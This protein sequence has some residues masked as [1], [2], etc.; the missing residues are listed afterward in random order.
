M[1]SKGGVRGGNKAAREFVSEAEE[2]LETMRARLADLSDCLG[3]GAEADPDLVNALF[4]A[5]HS[6]KALAGLFRFDPISSLAHKLEDVLDGLRLGRVAL[7]PPLCAWLDET[8]ALF[9]SLLGQ[10]GDAAALAGSAA[11]IEELTAGVAAITAPSAAPDEFASLALDPNVLRALTEYEEHR[12]RES[13]RRGRHIAVVDAPFE[14]KTFEEGLAELSSALR[15]SGEVLSTLPSPGDSLESQ[16][17]FSL[18][19]ATDLPPA[20]LA[21]RI[22]FPGAAARTVRAGRAVPAAVAAP[23][24]TPAQV[25][26]EAEGD[27]P[28]PI[29]ELESL[30]SISDTV[31]VDIRKLDD[32]MNL[33]GE[34]VIQRGAIGDLIARL[35]GRSETAKIGREFAKVHKVLDRKLRELQSAVLEVRMVPL[36]QVFEKVSRVVRRLRRELGKL[37][38]LEIRGADTELDKL[39]VEALVDPLMHVVRNALDHAIEP[40]E[41]RRALLKEESGRISIDA[42]QRGSHVVIEVRDD[43]RGI[44]RA[45][46]RR[47]AEQVGLVEPDAVLSDKETLDLIFAPGISTREQVTETSGRGVGMDIVRSNLAALGGVVDVESTPGR[48]TAIAITLPITLAIIQSLIVGVRDRRFA[49][50]LNSVLETLVVDAGAIQVSEGR[51]LL[52]LRGT[53]LLLR[54][55]DEEFG[56]TASARA[57]RPCVIVVGVG[58]QRLGLIVDRLEGQQDTVIKPI[59]GPVQNLRGISGATDLGD[60]DPVLVLDL[61]ALVEDALRRREAA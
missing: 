24:A 36:R 40:A 3:A 31:R 44:D 9:G 41:E 11:R 37:V 17:R 43:G 13:L 19:V 4:R 54:R 21:A 38:D 32:L 30:K 1:A 6:L 42:F 16:I 35:G 15:E 33:V 10:V 26:A 51:S 18:L 28:A 52:N 23:A 56:L 14:I 57:V 48:G 12:L 49:I 7:A 47:R 2:I 59:Q 50:P 46:L 27:A 25:P 34:L 8:I 58:E 22:E 61:S 5:A 53:P 29:P 55:I 60:Q 45:A 39:I 20:E